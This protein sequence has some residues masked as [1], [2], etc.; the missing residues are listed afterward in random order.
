MVLESVKIYELETSTV[1]LDSTLFHVYG[2]YQTDE[3]KSTEKNYKNYLWIF[4]R[5]TTR[6]KTIY[7]IFNLYKP[8]I[9][10]IVDKN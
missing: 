8:S 2:D 9:C 6:P 1:H 5:W 10:M 3:D 7:D 4:E